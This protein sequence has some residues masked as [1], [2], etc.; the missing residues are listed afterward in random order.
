MMIVVGTYSIEEV[1]PFRFVLD[2]ILHID[3]GTVFLKEF[4]QSL[5]LKEG[6]GGLR[7]TSAR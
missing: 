5:D 3:V 2:H 1:G 4:T 7:V 6:K